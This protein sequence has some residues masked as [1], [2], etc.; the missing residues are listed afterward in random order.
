MM[1]KSLSIVLV[2]VAAIVGVQ[3]LG[4]ASASAETSDSAQCFAVLV[5]DKAPGVILEGGRVGLETG[6]YHYETNCID[7]T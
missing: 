4:A 5:V 3:L 6:E 2:G 7:A 1:R